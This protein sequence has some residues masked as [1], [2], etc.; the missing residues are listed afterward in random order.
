MRMCRISTD[1]KTTTVSTKI[2]MNRANVQ[3]R[4]L[5]RLTEDHIL[6]SIHEPEITP[7]CVN[8]S[9]HTKAVVY[10]QFH[11]VDAQTDGRYAMFSKR[12]ARCV[13]LLV[14]Q[15]RPK[16]DLV[17]LQCV[18]GRSRSAGIAA[19]LSKYYNDDDTMFFRRYTPNMLVYRTMLNEMY[20]HDP[21]NFLGGRDEG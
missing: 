19:A 20:A 8:R 9:K 11:D 4:S 17:I 7:A 14:E 1:Q 6:I 12:D 13:R 21:L 18:M 10:L 15:W 5:I 3:G 2:V 16:L